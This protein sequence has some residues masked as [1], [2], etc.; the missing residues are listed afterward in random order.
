MTAS[1]KGFW[2]LAWGATL[3]SLALLPAAVLPAEAQAGCKNGEAPTRQLSQGEARRAVKC[4][5]NAQRTGKRQLELHKRLN[6][7]ALRHSRK[8]RAHSCLAHICPGEAELKR[9][10]R[11][12]RA[13]SHRWS[14]SE[15]VAINGAS[16]SPRDIVLQ[17]IT[18]PVHRDLLLG[19]FE[20]LG[21]GFATGG[22]LA[23]YTVDLGLKD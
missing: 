1:P 3:T 10:L 5:I 23:F 4:L 8:M 17:W 7:P 6:G 14:Y 19:R 18:S 12:Y 21:V 11:K 9:R 22:G 2:L 20:H 15:V 13:G 16:A